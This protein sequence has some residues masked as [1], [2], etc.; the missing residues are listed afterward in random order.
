MY[1]DDNSDGIMQRSTVKYVGYNFWMKIIEPI[2]EGLDI[3]VFINTLHN[4]HEPG[5]KTDGYS[6][7]FIKVQ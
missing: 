3:E 4:G 6:Y 2:E 5:S 1:D 7:L